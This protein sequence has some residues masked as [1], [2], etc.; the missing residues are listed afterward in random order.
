[1]KRPSQN[2]IVCLS[3]FC[4]MAFETEDVKADKS[5]KRIDVQPSGTQES[6]IRQKAPPRS[7]SPLKQEPSTSSKTCTSPQAIKPAASSPSKSRVSSPAP[8]TCGKG[9]PL[10]TKALFNT[11][12]PGLASFAQTQKS[13]LDIAVEEDEEE[14]DP[15]VIAMMADF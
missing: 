6:E 8:K 13:D 1:M 12:A 15:D 11:I 3:P 14:E 9:A 10:L 5:V 2:L 7:L 4:R